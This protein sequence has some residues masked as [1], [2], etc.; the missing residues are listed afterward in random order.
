M[1]RNRLR[2]SIA[3]IAIA[4]V[5]LTSAVAMGALVDLTS[6]F[7]S[8]DGKILFADDFNDNGAGWSNVGIVNGVG[9]GGPGIAQIG[10]DPL[11]SGES[12][13]FPSA[14]I[15]ANVQSF[16]TLPMPIDINALQ[17]FNVYFRARIEIDNSNARFN[18]QVIEKEATSNYYLLEPRPT[19]TSR[20]YY[21]DVNG[22][23]SNIQVGTDLITVS[24][25]F[26]NFRFTFI[27][28]GD[29]SMSLAGYVYDGSTQQW[30]LFTESV[31]DARFSTT[32]INAG[33]FDS[34]QI[35]SRNAGT[36]HRAVF[37]A[38]AITT[39]PE[40]ASLALL[41]LAVARLSFRRRGRSRRA[42]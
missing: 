19:I 38:F 28:T 3:P 22:T 5:F 2:R 18:S 39:I 41:G 31:L 37:D 35:S 8:Q 40:P 23:M 26:K 7:T 30:D 25:G 21:R 42:E 6:T 24:D 29:G 12:A 27:R 16:L 33:L 14:T 17:T 34:F 11:G 10:L 15:S 1:N 4:A 36:S 32:G 20:L 13:W 9:T